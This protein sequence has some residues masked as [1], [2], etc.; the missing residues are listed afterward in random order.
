MTVVMFRVGEQGALSDARRGF[1]RAGE[2]PP[3]AMGGSPSF[4]SRIFQNPPGRVVNPPVSR[5]EWKVSAAC[6]AELSLSRRDRAS[7]CAV[8]KSFTEPRLR[9]RRQACR[10][11]SDVSLSHR[12]WNFTYRECGRNVGLRFCALRERRVSLRDPGGM[13]APELPMKAFSLRLNRLR[14]RTTGAGRPA[15]CDF[16][17]GVL[18]Y[19]EGQALQSNHR[20]P[21]RTS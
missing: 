8:G 18:H 21:G 2:T 5:S 12:Q 6:T 14:L 4:T 20:P 11:R 19:S 3:F 7:G 10:L 9:R 1:A 13:A 16:P 15:P 17:A